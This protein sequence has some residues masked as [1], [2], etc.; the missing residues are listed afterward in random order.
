M[1]LGCPYILP[2][3]DKKGDTIS[4]LFTSS[5]G[6]KSTDNGLVEKSIKLPIFQTIGDFNVT[7][8]YPPKIEGQLKHGEKSDPV[9]K[10]LND[11]CNEIKHVSSYFAL[12]N[13][14]ASFTAIKESCK[15]IIN[16]D[17]R[18]GILL[19]GETGTGKSRLANE[20]SVGAFKHS[21]PLQQKK[22]QEEVKITECLIETY[23]ERFSDVIEMIEYAQENNTIYNEVCQQ[24]E[25]KVKNKTVLQ[26]RE[27]NAIRAVLEQKLSS[28]DKAAIIKKAINLYRQEARQK[29]KDPEIVPVNCA[30]LDN[31]HLAGSALFGHKAGSFTDAKF[32][33]IGYLKKADKGVLFLDEIGALP[34]TT[35]AKLLKAIEE[36]TF[37]RVGSEEKVESDF[38]LI[39]GTNSNLQDEIKKVTFRK[40]LYA[41]ISTFTYTL[42]PLRKRH[43]ELEPSIDKLLG[44]I[45]K[46][47]IKKQ[48]YEDEDAKS[49]KSTGKI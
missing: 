7:F 37:N 19:M 48:N 34:L 15:M 14:D 30:T 44:E 1:T 16:R 27:I 25:L 29:I 42:P 24:L 13:Q 39:C 4:L 36:H 23:I 49:K 3:E 12:G 9:G 18:G 47:R 11:R 45:E 32:D 26:D 46:N 40:D 31:E 2:K 22:S 6:D 35:Q 17:T 21:Q 8:Q 5:S 28:N 41:R 20:I 33:T 38:F 10:F 43:E